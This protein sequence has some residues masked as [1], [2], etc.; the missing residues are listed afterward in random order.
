MQIVIDIDKDKYEWIKKNNQNKKNVDS[1][2]VAFANG[3]PY[4]ER[5]QGECRG[6]KYYFNQVGRCENCCRNPWYSDNFSK[7]QMKGG[8]E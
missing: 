6:C 7:A 2:V 5:P 4:E 3:I 1:I 8:T